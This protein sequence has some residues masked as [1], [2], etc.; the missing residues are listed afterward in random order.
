MGF[1]VLLF[2]INS[3]FTRQVAKHQREVAL[4]TSRHTSDVLHF[5]LSACRVQCSAEMMGV[6]TSVLPWRKLNAQKLLGS[7]SVPVWWQ[8]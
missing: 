8:E 3:L 2:E 6:I 4:V 5:P 1:A 7:S